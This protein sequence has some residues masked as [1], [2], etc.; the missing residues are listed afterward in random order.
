MKR[1]VHLQRLATT[2][3]YQRST[4]DV[5]YTHGKARADQKVEPAQGS[6]GR[7][8]N[9]GAMFCACIRRNIRDIEKAASKAKTHHQQTSRG[10]AENPINRIVGEREREEVKLHRGRDIGEKM[11][12]WRTNRSKIYLKE[13]KQEGNRHMGD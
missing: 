10:R 7:A 3:L 13:V 1:K 12:F 4:V 2:L 11:P 8:S 9:R 6:S 5:S